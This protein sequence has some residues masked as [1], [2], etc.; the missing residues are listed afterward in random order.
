MGF[1]WDFR[2]KKFCLRASF[3]G[4]S[5]NDIFR[6]CC[7]WIARKEYGNEKSQFVFI[8]AQLALTINTLSAKHIK[9]FKWGDKLCNCMNMKCNYEN[10]RSRIFV[11]YYYICHTK[12]WALAFRT[13]NSSNKQQQWQHS[14][15][16]LEYVVA[17]CMRCA[18][19]LANNFNVTKHF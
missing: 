17:A 7:R 3:V 4:F 6:R 8:F 14:T 2:W 16:T 11:R 13:A 15:S 9:R 18:L 1:R 10:F 19:L 5:Q 12:K